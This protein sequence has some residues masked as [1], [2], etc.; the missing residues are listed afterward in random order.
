MYTVTRQLQWPEGTPMVEVSVGGIDYCNPDALVARY[1]GE[2]E[3]FPNPIEAVETA[4]DIC[5]SWRKDGEK[6][7]QIG[8]GAT[9]GMTMPFEECSFKSA[10]EWAKKKYASLPKCPQCGDI[11]ED[12]QEKWTSGFITSEGELVLDD[13]YLY[14]SEHCAEKNYEHED[15]QEDLCQAK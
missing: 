6:E 8:I 10:R 1:G 15:E 2:F 11:I 12:G 13:E 4:I 5:R 7:A 14:C 3:E 9:L